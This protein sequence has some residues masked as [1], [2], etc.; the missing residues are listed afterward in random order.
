M[1]HKK[2]HRV[3]AAFVFALILSIASCSDVPTRPGP[4]ESSSDFVAE[5]MVYNQI[6]APVQSTLRLVATSQRQTII[7]R[8]AGQLDVAGDDAGF[9]L[10]DS[11][12]ARLTRFQSTTLLSHALAA[13]GSAAK[14]V[15]KARKVAA[16]RVGEKNIALAAVPDADRASGRPPRAMLILDNDRI[17]AI[18][19][20]TW[21]KK[22]GVW[23]VQ[24]SRTTFLNEHGQVSSVFEQDASDLAPRHSR[25]VSVLEQIR[26]GAD[27]VLPALGRLVQPDALYAATEEEGVC[28]LEGIAAAAAGAAVIGA[29]YAVQAME[30]AFAVASAALAAAMTG[31]L[32]GV[33]TCPAADAALVAYSI[34]L[35]NLRKAQYALA[36]AVLAA[37]AADYALSECLRKYRERQQDPSSQTVSGPNSGGNET[38]CGEGEEEWCEWT[39]TWPDGVLRVHRNTCWCQEGEYAL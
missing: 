2:V 11:A 25:D 19:E 38:Y 18:T 9:Q 8:A 4:T 6:W 16:H 5:G 15:L 3:C 39:L 12:T 27:R 1:H 20:Y 26:N 30:A 28:I 10:A 14:V 36:G 17:A 21:R 35:A 29:G 37:G 34:A 13:P 22:G 32:V 23:L 31:C 7:R 24:Q 33:I